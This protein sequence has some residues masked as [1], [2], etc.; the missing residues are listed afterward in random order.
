MRGLA[1]EQRAEI[2][3]LFPELGDSAG[4]QT[5]CAARMSLKKKKTAP[6]L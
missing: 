4:L 6:L 3:S 2:I 1:N 5:Y